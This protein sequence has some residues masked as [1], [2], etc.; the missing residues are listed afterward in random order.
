MPININ[1]SITN[2]TDLSFRADGWSGNKQ[3][4][5]NTKRDVEKS[6]CL[7]CLCSNCKLCELKSSTFVY[8]NSVLKICNTV[9]LLFYCHNFD[10]LVEKLS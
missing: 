7:I 4:K 9:R 5:K 1:I 10:S 2:T 6:F 8:K 3:I